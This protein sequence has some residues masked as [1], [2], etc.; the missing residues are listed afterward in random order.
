[1]Y[2]WRHVSHRI[3]YVRTE[4]VAHIRGV[5]NYYVA[6]SHATFE[7]QPVSEKDMANRVSAISKEWPYVVCEGAG[8]LLGYAYAAPWRTRSAY[9]YSVEASVYVSAEH[10]G[11]GIGTSLYEVL[12]VDLA[13]RGIHAVMAGISLPNEASERLH[14]QFGFVKVA[15]LQEV[16]YKLDRWIDVAYWELIL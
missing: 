11:H 14:R 5:Y 13:A 4:D 10:R 16:G 12:L 6:S 7:E 9:R 15:H 8:G 1:M 2:P 3:R